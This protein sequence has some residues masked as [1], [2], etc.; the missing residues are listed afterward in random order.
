MPI[1]GFANGG[2]ISNFFNGKENTRILDPSA[3]EKIRSIW[4]KQTQGSKIK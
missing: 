4:K 2:E 3:E 1:G